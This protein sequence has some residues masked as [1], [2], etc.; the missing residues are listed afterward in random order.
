MANILVVDDE[1]PMRTVLRRFFE[2]AEH[3]V[4]EAPNGAQALAELQNETI[5][6]AF[7]DMAMPVMDGLGLLRRMRERFPE[8]HVVAMS[9]AVEVL[10]LP[11]REM[12]IVGVL[13]KPFT[14]DEALEAL[15]AALSE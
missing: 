1:A 5:D 7:V 11:Q 10:D 13:E 15:A 2:A 6:V 3:K 14:R 4:L 9:R 12:K 8:V